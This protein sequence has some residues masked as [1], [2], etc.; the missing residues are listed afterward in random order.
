MLE[1]NK[2]KSFKHWNLSSN[3][4]SKNKRTRFDENHRLGEHDHVST[5]S[6]NQEV[7]TKNF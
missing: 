1:L 5:Q 3:Y 2:N 6:G 7:I 4:Y